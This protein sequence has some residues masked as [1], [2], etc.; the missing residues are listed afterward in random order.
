MSSGVRKLL[1]EQLLW[2]KQ[3]CCRCCGRGE[4]MDEKR[5][6]TS[7]SDGL[8]GEWLSFEEVKKLDFFQG[9]D[10]DFKIKLNANFG[11]RP[12]SKQQSDATTP[13]PEPGIKAAVKRQY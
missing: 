4:S 3:V 6:G 5:A 7:R 13:P 11:T 9:T 8:E 2:Y 12:P 10:R 1:E